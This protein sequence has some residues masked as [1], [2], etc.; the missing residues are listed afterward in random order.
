M[1]SEI[2]TCPT[3]PMKYLVMPIN[4]KSLALSQWDHVGVTHIE[5]KISGLK[6]NLLSFGARSLW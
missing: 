5:T 3:N 4:E 2:F 1:Y 6:G